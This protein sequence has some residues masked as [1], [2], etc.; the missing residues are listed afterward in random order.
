MFSEIK[1]ATHVFKN[2][3]LGDKKFCFRRQEISLMETINLSQ[4]T[5]KIV[6]LLKTK[7]VLDIFR[8]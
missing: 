8:E 6:A 1:K 7:S 5:Y 4:E 3:V 2:L